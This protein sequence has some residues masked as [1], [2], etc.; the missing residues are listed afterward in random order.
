MDSPQYRLSRGAREPAA[1]VK[2]LESQAVL[3]GTKS[4]D[5]LQGRVHSR[6]SYDAQ[7]SRDDYY[8][9]G[10]PVRNSINKGSATSFEAM[11]ATVAE[12]RRREHRTPSTAPTPAISNL[13]KAHYLKSKKARL[14]V[15]APTRARA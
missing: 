13:R 2:R 12:D 11:R 5:F 15:A 10:S 4:P 9:E 8:S 14:S 1:Q 3:S 7:N 6:S